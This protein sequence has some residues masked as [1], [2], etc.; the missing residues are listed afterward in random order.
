M[1]LLRRLLS[2]PAEQATRAQVLN[3]IERETGQSFRVRDTAGHPEALRAAYQ[4]V[5]DWCV[6]RYPQTGRALDGDVRDH[7]A[8]WNLKLKSVRW[9]SGDPGRGQAA[10]RAKGCQMCH[11]PG[12]SIGPPLTGVAARYPPAELF[13]AI[14]FPNREVA[15]PYRSTT[16]QMRNKQT[17]TGLVISDTPEHILLQTGATTTVR[18]HPDDIVSRQEILQSIM[19]SGLVGDLGLQELADLYGYLRSL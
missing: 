1:L 5:F 16:F 8:M 6:Q 2:E 10:F 12:A 19:P 17:L 3:L 14:M 7:S 18:L 13:H 4:P 9:D 11:T 15:E